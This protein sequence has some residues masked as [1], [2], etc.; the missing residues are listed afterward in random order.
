MQENKFSGTLSMYHS[1]VQ[2]LCT[3]VDKLVTSNLQICFPAPYLSLHAEY[4][5]MPN[6]PLGRTSPG[7]PYGSCQVLAAAK[8]FP[9][10]LP[11]AMASG[12][13]AIKKLESYLQA[14]MV[15]A[16]V[17]ASR[18]ASLH[19]LYAPHY[20]DPVLFSLTWYVRQDYVL[21]VL[22]IHSINSFSLD[23]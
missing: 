4:S 6:M 12:I 13:V 11:R 2:P 9:G 8:A 5:H 17:K 1:T 22:Q 20:S 16:G 14:Y 21:I 15:A 18:R 3:H 7:L 10:G 19:S 23:W